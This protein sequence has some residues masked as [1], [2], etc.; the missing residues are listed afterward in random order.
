M[1]LVSLVDENRQW[2][3]SCSG[4]RV[5]ET[6]RS[7]SFCGHAILGDD[8]FIVPDALA[9]E[10][11]ADNPL[12]VKE[13]HIRFYAGCPLSA[14]DGRKLGT[15][16]I[17]DHRPRTLDDEDRGLLGDLAAI[18]ESELGALHLAMVDELT[19]I[20]NRRGFMMLAQQSLHLCERENIPAS[21]VFVD[22]NNFKPVNDRFGHAEGDRVLALFANLMTNVFRNSDCVGRLGGD[23]FVVLFSH[24]SLEGA[25]EAIAR[26]REALDD[27]NRKANRGYDISFSHGIVEFDPQRHGTIGALV[28]EGDALMYQ[29][30]QSRR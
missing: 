27:I 14:P 6:P 24:L 16:C 21:L 23:E 17:I 5:R 19:D 4:L 30:K 7:L 28:A 9:D 15:L 3:K 26:F 18:V 13:P 29:I 20:S 1:A 11:F 10:R 25:E 2:F 12:V 22:L 8:I